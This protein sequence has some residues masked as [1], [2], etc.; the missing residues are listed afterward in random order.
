ML[1]VMRKHAYSWG[2]RILLGL[3][4]VVFVFWGIGSGF[5]GQVHAVATVDGQKILADEVQRQADVMRRSFQNMYGP[6]AV[7]LLKHINLREQALEQ[8]IDQRLVE[9]AG[10][11]MGLRVSNEEL[12]DAIAADRAF[13]VDG[14]F[15][16]QAYEAV[17]R[18]NGM[19][20]PEFEDLRRAELTTRLLHDMVT[21]A[22][23]LS[24]AQARQTYNQRNERV[25]VG[26]LEVPWADFEPQIHPTQAQIEKF[27]KDNGETFREPARVK[28]EYIYYDPIMLGQK[29]NPTDKE[30]ADFYK[31][32]LKKLFDHPETVHASHILIAASPTEPEKDRQEAK[33]K[34]EKILEQLKQGADFAKLAKQDSDDQGTRDHGGDLG[35]FQR[36]QMIKPFEDVA[37]KLKAGQL[38]SVVET[39]FG[40][41]IIRVEEVKPAHT[42]TLEQARP[43][44]VQM[45]TE[46]AGRREAISDQREDL[47]AALN[48]AKLPDLAAKH[49]LQAVTTPP[50]AA[51]EPIPKLDRNPD[52]TNAVF[53][54]G[55]GEVGAVN[56]KESGLFLVKVVDREPAHIP[57]LKD[58]QDRVHD[59]LVRRDA[60][61]K[62]R[63]RAEALL[64]QI[65]NAADFNKVAEANHL[66][67]H[68]TEPFDR[69]S[70]SVPTI[71]DFPEVTQGVGGIA[72]IPGVIPKVMVQSG[73]YYIV[74][75]L[76][77][78]APDDEEWKKAES[79]FKEE[80]L[81]SMRSQAWENFVAGLKR[82]ARI[83]IDPN[84]L[85]SGPVESSM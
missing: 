15:D 3:I 84:A 73:N 35:F 79:S 29:V 22:V 16:L 58:I 53:K 6:Q 45:L 85:G 32:N 75:L 23:V 72:S 5:F 70:S 77:R 21:Q 52:F 50:F 71:G 17:L 42:D 62:A 13:Q 55:K 51:D 47:A 14:Q 63:D 10:H 49:N 65:K 40:Y 1:N 7:E 38:S 60:E 81:Q 64:K 37:F 54:L 30:I 34:A 48:G 8:L 39:R 24:D 61:S 25:S 67:I 33:A 44:I 4:T 68:K 41:H 80:L 59:A 31:R 36:G 28:V 66:T 20:P 74:E 76:S 78:Q 27:Y 9:R 83:T 18:D 57:A 2:I 69:A 43:R 26:Y 82:Q 11:R 12:R 46:R 19:S 56:G